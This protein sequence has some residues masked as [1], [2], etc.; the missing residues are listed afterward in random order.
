MPS[1]KEVRT[2]IESV[3]S[4]KQIT[5]AMKMVAAAKLRK[6]Q[7]AIGTMRP[8]AT[9]LRE[10]M[11]QIVA[12]LPAGFSLPQAEQREGGKV[13]VIP[14]TSNRGLCGTFNTTVIRTAVK[15]IAEEFSA[16]QQQNELELLCIGRKGDEF[17][18]SRKYQVS[19]THNAL[20]DKLS[21][22]AVVKLADQL[23]ESFLSGEYNKIVFVYSQFRSA[24]SQTVVT[25]QFLPIQLPVVDESKQKSTVEYLFEPDGAQILGELVPKTL[26]TQ[27]FKVML[28]SLAS[29]N[30]ARMIAMHKAT[31]NATEMLRHLRLSYNKAR[32]A[33]I[34]KEILEIV[35]G[36]NA[37]Q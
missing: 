17:F 27:V 16:Q 13:L 15:L 2:R 34:T 21:F 8:Y 37:L 11:Q 3:N 7:Q 19:G 30:G 9:K 6:S 14:V 20:L 22:D 23:M 35:A 1:L 12:G 31:D 26:R 25:E 32:Q 29:E 33:A 18:K 36:A 10:M 24:G 4:T 5:S 28:D